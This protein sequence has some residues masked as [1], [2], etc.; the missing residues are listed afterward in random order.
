MNLFRHKSEYQILEDKINYQTEINKYIIFSH[1]QKNL[2]NFHCKLILRNN[3]IYNFNEVVKTKD[4]QLMKGCKYVYVSDLIDD[5]K[6]K[7]EFNKLSSKFICLNNG[8]YKLL[9]D[10]NIIYKCMKQDK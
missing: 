6:F 5:Y 8:I 10:E 2:K 7:T 3:I 4:L 9:Y 1:L